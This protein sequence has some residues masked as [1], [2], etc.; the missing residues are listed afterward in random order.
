MLSYRE[1]RRIIE[2]QRLRSTQT[3][4]QPPTTFWKIANA[5]I[6]LWL[7]STVAIGA[8]S[9]TITQHQNCTSAFEKEFLEFKKLSNEISERNRLLYRKLA[10]TANN[11]EYDRQV[12]LFKNGESFFLYSEFK[13]KTIPEL[14]LTR[15]V[16]AKK[17]KPRWAPPTQLDVCSVELQ[18]I[19]E[20]NQMRMLS[21]NCEPRNT[22]PIIDIESE[23]RHLNRSASPVIPSLGPAR[24]FTKEH[25]ASYFDYRRMNAFRMYLAYNFGNAYVDKGEYWDIPNKCSLKQIWATWLGPN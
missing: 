11:D 13:G 8:L 17:L 20:L 25:E 24:G 14:S 5:P 16:L 22:V 7:L 1:R 15:T 10:D 19:P 3:G 12:E 21:A 4:S 6:T 2:E 23:P 18:T 9:A